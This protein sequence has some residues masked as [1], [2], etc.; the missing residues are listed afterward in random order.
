MIRKQIYIS[1]QQEAGLKAIAALSGRKESE[2][3]REGL[4]YIIETKTPREKK[5]VEEWKEALRAVK[6]I[7]KDRDDIDEIM[8]E[9]RRQLKERA[10]RYDQPAD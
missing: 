7:W 2:L 1:E 9:S 8:Q 6:G 10:K 4:D 3:L 5:D